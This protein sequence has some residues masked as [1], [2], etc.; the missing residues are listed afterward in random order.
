MLEKE[1]EE[2]M[3]K[4]RKPFSEGMNDEEKETTPRSVKKIG[5]DSNAEIPPLDETDAAEALLQNR[6]FLSE[7][8]CDDTSWS[9]RSP[10]LAQILSPTSPI[11]A[12]P[13]RTMIF[14]P[15][16]ILSPW[17]KAQRP[18]IFKN[19]VIGYKPRKQHLF[20]RLPNDPN[21]MMKTSKARCKTRP[22]KRVVSISPAINLGDQHD[23]SRERGMRVQTWTQK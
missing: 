13:R 18:S 8:T 7:S 20:T 3:L 22:P 19:G 10:L 6:I 17:S 9:K 4:L 11:A 14:L 23:R 21:K 2:I 12:K 16:Q 1:I 5:G 15:K